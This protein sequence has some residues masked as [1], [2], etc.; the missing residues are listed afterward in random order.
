MDGSPRIG[1]SNGLK[2]SRVP[3]AHLLSWLPKSPLGASGSRQTSVSL[4]RKEMEVRGWD[5]MA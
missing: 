4:Q 3:D 2:A 1:C 5:A